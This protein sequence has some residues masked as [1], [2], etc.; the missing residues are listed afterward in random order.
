MIFPGG[1]KKRRAE[2]RFDWIFSLILFLIQL[3]ILNQ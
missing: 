2:F 1:E 3:I